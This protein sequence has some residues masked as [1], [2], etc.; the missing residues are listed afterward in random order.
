[1]LLLDACFEGAV[2]LK[3]QAGHVARHDRASTASTMSGRHCEHVDESEHTSQEVMHALHFVKTLNDPSEHSNE[4]DCWFT[5][6]TRPGEH[7]MHDVASRHARQCPMQAVH[8]FPSAND[9]PW[10][11]VEHVCLSTDNTFP[12][13]H[14]V[15]D[16]T[17]LSFGHVLQSARQSLQAVLSTLAEYCPAEH[18]VQD[19]SMDDEPNA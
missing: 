2:T 18:T 14:S 1:V 16:A 19:A 17:V 9:G 12:S 11:A 13:I 3:A 15:H 7:I 10:H 6:R 4:H 8:I 5:S